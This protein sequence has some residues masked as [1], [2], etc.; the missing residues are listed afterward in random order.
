MTSTRDAGLLPIGFTVRLN[1]HVRVRDQGR[2][3]VGGAP[4]RMIRLSPAAGDYL[5]ERTIRVRDRSSALLADRLIEGGL[6]DPIVA[7]LP[8]L[9]PAQV[10][11]V[12]P[13]RDRPAAL[14]RL[15]TCIGDRHHVIVVD[16]ASLAPAAIADVVA[17]HRAELVALK[18]NVGPATAR[19]EGLKR[20]TTPYVAFADDDVVLEP[21]ALPLLLRHFHDPRVAMVAP[22]VL[23]LRLPGRDRWVG[24]YEDARSSL[25]LGVHPGIVRPRAPVSWVPSACLLARVDA[26]GS[27]FSAGMRVG[28]DVD[29]AWRLAGEG[30]RVR[31]EPAAIVHHEHR[32][33]I[34]DWLRRKAFYG[35]GADLLAQRHGRDVAPAIVTPWSAAFAAALLLQRRWSLPAA[36]LIFAAATLRLS[37]KV[38]NTE[39]PVRLGAA[40]TF[41]RALAATWQLKA[42]LLRHWWPL[43]A[44]GCLLSRR[45]RR[46]VA[47]AA[48][49][50]TVVDFRRTK[51]HLDPFRFAIARRL[52]DVAYGCGVW[53]GAF[54]GRSLRALLPDI[55][56]K[57]THSHHER[58]TDVRR[59]EIR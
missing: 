56:W 7:D 12:I 37:S 53:Y 28:E 25:D 20:V 41:D 23:G 14:D 57:G 29:L 35:T 38:R 34:P 44:I 39:R 1:R 9:D 27:G 49:F 43:A 31:Y 4:T 58:S 50:D 21:D 54:K 13:V 59:A 5:H 33:A 40:L 19:N 8:D 48:L 52:D 3:L 22:R 45:M 55:R 47:A 36:A 26:L 18:R 24:R 16:D 11:V 17:R 32:T 46:A 51:A 2:T 30:H 42:L 15:L 6:A 10:T